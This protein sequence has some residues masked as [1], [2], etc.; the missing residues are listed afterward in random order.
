MHSHKVIIKDP[1]IILYY[2]IIVFETENTQYN[3]SPLLY[4]DACECSVMLR[5]DLE[6][7]LFFV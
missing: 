2:V 4:T 5:Q 7:F 6:D 3:W 1:I